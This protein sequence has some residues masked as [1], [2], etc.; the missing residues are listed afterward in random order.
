[1][2]NVWTQIPQALSTVATQY[3]KLILIVGLDPALNSQVLQSIADEYNSPPI[4]LTLH[5]GREMTGQSNLDVG[6]IVTHFFDSLP[7]HPICI[8]AIDLL[9]DQSLKHVIDPFVLLRRQS[10]QQVI[11]STWLGIYTHP[12][13]YY[14]M[15]GHD[16][17]R[18]Y[19][20]VD[21]I[22]LH[23]N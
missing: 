12:Y 16:E 23:T 18:Q 1:M 2:H 15:H 6:H 11:V 21:V 3:H 10:R 20:D 9:F 19:H 4:N 17:Y 14:A 5:L 22:V 13:L 8:D 7:Q